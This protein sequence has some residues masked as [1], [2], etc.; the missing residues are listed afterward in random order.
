M[1]SPAS[2]TAIWA[3]ATANWLARDMR[4]ASLR[5]R[6]WPGSNSGTSPAICELSGVGSNCVMRR[7]PPRPFFRLSQNASTPAS[8]AGRQRGTERG[9]ST[10][11]VLGVK[12]PIEPDESQGSE[13]GENQEGV[14]GRE[15]VERRLKR[16]DDAGRAH[17]AEERGGTPDDN[18]ASGHDLFHLL[19]RQDAAILHAPPASVKQRLGTTAPGE[20]GR[21]SK[22]AFRHRSG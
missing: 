9:R 13:R 6:Y 16:Q 11:Q 10:A 8:P 7:I 5:F 15:L 22:A 14:D 20:P 2:W 19:G 4:R 3:A 17:Q 18:A 21:P 12:N 1:V